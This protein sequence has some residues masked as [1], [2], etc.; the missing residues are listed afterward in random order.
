LKTMTCKQ[1]AGACDVEFHAET[2]EEIGE[3]SRQHAMKMAKDG[4]RPHIEKMDE[5][6][7]LMK[8]PGAVDEWFAK[9]RAEFDSLPEDE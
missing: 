5:M 3:L 4:D 6:K 7:G 8:T 1:L 2:F 9:M